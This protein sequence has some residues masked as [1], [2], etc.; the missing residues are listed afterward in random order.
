MEA[1]GCTKLRRGQTA[2]LNAIKVD[3]SHKDTRRSL[4]LIMIKR[5]VQLSEWSVQ[6]GLQLHQVD[7]TTAFLNG[8]L[9][10]EVYMQQPRGFVFEG[11]EN[12]V[13]KLKKSI[14]G[15][16]KSPRCWNTALDKQLKEM[17][18]VQSTSDPCIYIDAGDVFFIGVYVDDIILASRENQKSERI[19]VSKVRGDASCT[20]PTNWRYLDRTA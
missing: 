9:E 16:K 7:V 19:S 8:E 14:Y 18:F 13:C 17:G 15:L 1:S 5:S 12:L 3:W 20:G 6:F 2:R 11:K 4:E 10:V